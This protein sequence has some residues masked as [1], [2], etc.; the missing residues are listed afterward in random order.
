MRLRAFASCCGVAL[1]PSLGHAASIGVFFDPS[2]GSC[3]GTVPIPSFVTFYVIAFPDPQGNGI[4]GAEFRLDGVPAEGWYLSASPSSAAAVDIGNPFL[5][6]CNIAFANCRSGAGGVLLYT[7][8][9]AATTPVTNQTLRIL[10][11]TLP[12]DLGFICP[13]VTLC[14]APDYTMVCVTG[15]E[16]VINGACRA[17]VVSSFNPTSGPAGTSVTIDGSYF[18]D[19]TNVRFNGVD[20]SFTVNSCTQIVAIAPAT[21]VGNIRVTTSCGTDS[22]DSPFIPTDV[23]PLAH[24]SAI[25]AWPNPFTNQV[26]IGVH[27]QSRHCVNLD[28]FDVAGRRVRAL[29]AV[30]YGPGQAVLVW[31][32]RDQGGNQ[33]PAGHYYLRVRW[34]GFEATRL[35]SRLHR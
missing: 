34:P 33:Q 25:E 10:R 29:P 18:D 19:V 31:D 26:H 35:V 32:G 7:I 4:T 6:G 2:G 11:R 30:D 15:G 14:D 20:A 16:A 17:P 9:G 3:N 5:E 23:V 1:I 22:T 24:T 28:V 12:T 27:M 8:T 13:L 21:T